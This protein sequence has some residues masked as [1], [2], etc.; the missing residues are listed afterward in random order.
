MTFV[1]SIAAT[2][3]ATSGN[4][5]LQV[6]QRTEEEDLTPYSD[7][8]LMTDYEFKILRS[9]VGAF[10][11]PEHFERAITE[12]ARAGWEMVEKFDNGR[13]RFKRPRSAREQDTGLRASG[14]DPYR[15]SFRGGEGATVMI[16]IVVVASIG[17][18]LAIVMAMA[19]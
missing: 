19:K 1:P 14:V 18:F 7:E 15:T 12:E 16:V 17:G 2:T 9:A 6:L 3:A 11:K 5:H 8:E 4:A 13:I 10:A